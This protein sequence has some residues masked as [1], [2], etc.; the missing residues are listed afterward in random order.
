MLSCQRCRVGWPIHEGYDNYCGYCATR[1]VDYEIEIKGGPLYID[2]MPEEPFL[3]L[4]L[5]NTGS[6]PVDV[7]SIEARPAWLKPEHTNE[8]TV[9]VGKFREIKVGIYMDTSK[10]SQTGLKRLYSG[11]IEVKAANAD[12]KNVVLEVLPPPDF[13]FS[14]EHMTFGNLGS[15]SGN[16]EVAINLEVPIKRSNVAFDAVKAE[17]ACQD[18]LRIPDELRQRGL[19][20]KAR[21]DSLLIPV[22]INMRKYLAKSEDTEVDARSAEAT[23]SFKIMGREKQEERSIKLIYKQPPGLRISGVSDI[24][25]MK[26]RW[27]KEKEFELRLEN[28]GGGQ[29]D[30]AQL[31]F[32]GQPKWLKL[33]PSQGVIKKDEEENLTVIVDMEKAPEGRE[34]F[35]L[36]HS[37]GDKLFASPFV[38]NI[39]VQVMPTYPRYL[40]VDFGTTNSCCA[41]VDDGN[42]LE[43]I[44]YYEGAT[45]ETGTLADKLVTSEIIYKDES[46]GELKYEVGPLAWHQRLSYGTANYFRSIK[47][48]LGTDDHRYIH[49]DGKIIPLEPYQ[50]AGH[51]IQFLLETASE[52]VKASIVRCVAGYPSRFNHRA[53][54]ELRDIYKNLGIT[55][56]LMLD[57]ATAA[58]LEYVFERN[59]QNK[60]KPESYYI[61]VY[62]F[63]GGTTDIALLLVHV[64]EGKLRIKHTDSGGDRGLGGDDITELIISSI[65]QEYE[66]SIRAELVA[67][68]PGLADVSVEI[69]V[70]R[71]NDVFTPSGSNYDVKLIENTVALYEAAED[72]KTDLSDA[73]AKE[74]KALK[75]PTSEIL[76]KLSDQV[77]TER[78]LNLNI[79]IGGKFSILSDILPMNEI[80]FSAKYSLI[81]EYLSPKLDNVL[82]QV[83]AMFRD[84]ETDHRK[85]IMLAGQSSAIPLVKQ[86]IEQ[87]FSQAEIIV[88]ADLKGCVAKGLERYG[89]IIDAGPA[90]SSIEISSEF[91]NKIYSDYGIK[92]VDGFF[93][94]T[95]E[96]VL[97]RKSQ[98]PCVG[99]FTRSLRQQAVVTIY[100]NT[101]VSKAFRGNDKIETVASYFHDF[102][103]DERIS[104]SSLLNVELEMS[105]TNDQEIRLKAKIDSKNYEFARM[106]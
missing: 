7:E 59:K 25:V 93:D 73:M 50:I 3:M 67:N 99:A 49:L 17:G 54:D 80:G 55:D 90:A 44:T 38:L 71:V 35:E 10:L 104:E 27:N 47:R 9:P 48:K 75:N 37:L 39:D 83:E 58:A 100:E 19:H 46:R 98:I 26:G 78:S 64:E 87:R 20:L 11:D 51:I 85:L 8:L 76:R 72:I 95:F 13:G 97:K 14:Q 84:L 96:A 65:I 12:N 94:E 61:L 81:E 5:R 74:L 102:S 24:T 6:V 88:P 43:L 45:E 89:G 52:K 22:L 70:C 40:A 105:M 36:T 30:I 16:V 79:S 82:A 34:S 53:I 66:G 68:N 31:A 103:E 62:D 15:S 32:K 106:T 86:K 33:S 2:E 56:I 28:V 23:L 29:I 92:T 4:N 57:E 1:V 101:S 69:P 21:Q 18:W 91:V 41:R 63:G 77:E 60:G 42:E